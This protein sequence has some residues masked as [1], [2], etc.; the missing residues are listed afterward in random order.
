MSI[1]KHYEVITHEVTEKICI[2]ETTY[3][4]ICKKEIDT[5]FTETVTFSPPT[6][7]SVVEQKQK[8]VSKA[9]IIVLNTIVI[10]AAGG[11]VAYVIGRKKFYK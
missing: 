6:G 11:G 4:D 7:L 2:G 5:N 9:V 3:C 8:T 10:V 1:K